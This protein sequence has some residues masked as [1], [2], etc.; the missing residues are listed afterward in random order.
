MDVLLN[1]VQSTIPALIVFLTIYLVL[2]KF[3]QGQENMKA[4]ELKAN[5]QSQS[6]PLRMQAYER[7]SLFCER[8]NL[9]SLLM[10][11]NKE[12]LNAGQLHITMMM[13]IQTEYEHNITQQIYVSEN[14][15][16]IIQVAKDDA[17]NFLSLVAQEVGTTATA[18]E[19]ERVLLENIQKRGAA[20][21]DA[22]LLAIKK[23]A[24][25]NF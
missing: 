13:A 21:T 24:S 23:E 3:I 20:P 22:A 1:I 5:Q 2:K 7:L 14:L 16:K 8:I 11:M 17:I 19:Y 6:L 9:A 4:Y 12:G 18:R 10:R 25:L 15:W